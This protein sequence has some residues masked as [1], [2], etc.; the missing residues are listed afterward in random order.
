MPNYRPFSLRQWFCIAFIAGS[1]LSGIIMQMEEV[2]RR[3]GETM[4][5]KQE[6]QGAYIRGVVDTERVILSDIRNYKEITLSDGR[7]VVAVFH[8]LY[9]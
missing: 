7:I 5:H 4:R 6:V 1:L 3:K 2:Y 9:K 8:E